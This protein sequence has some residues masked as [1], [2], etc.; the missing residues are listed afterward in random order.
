MEEIDP[1]GVTP[2]VASLY[3]TFKRHHYL[4]AV[5]RAAR[6][7]GFFDTM[8]QNEL[9][10]IPFPDDPPIIYPDAEEWEALT[11]RRKKYASVDLSARSKA[12]EQIEVGT[13]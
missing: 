9:S 13:P 1:D 12:E 3:A 6:W 10:S 8:Y 5:T 11:A 7:Q 4:Q 2:R